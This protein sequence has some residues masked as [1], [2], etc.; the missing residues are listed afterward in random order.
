[1]STLPYLYIRVAAIWRSLCVDMDFGSSPEEITYFPKMSWVALVVI[2][3]LFLDINKASVLT[4]IEF[5]ICNQSLIAFFAAGVRKI[6]RSLLPFP[7]T[8]KISLFTWSMFKLASSD[9]LN[10]QLRKQWEIKH[11]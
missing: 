3:L 10:V 9:N 4:L 1:M 7:T 5:L 11:G 2:R 6:L 8:D